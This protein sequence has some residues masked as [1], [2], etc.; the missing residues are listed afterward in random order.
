M[1]KWP[2]FPPLPSHQSA[3]N[4]KRHVCESQLCQANLIIWSIP[5]LTD[6]EDNHPKIK[7]AIT[8]WQIKFT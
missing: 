2:N 8:L 1:K 7:Q 4:E 3:G 6:V 5:L